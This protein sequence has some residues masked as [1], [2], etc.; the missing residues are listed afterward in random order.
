MDNEHRQGVL[1]LST[2]NEGVAEAKPRKS[3]TKD[4]FIVLT[5]TVATFIT[6][7]GVCL[8]IMEGVLAALAQQVWQ[9]AGFVLLATVITGTVLVNRGLTRYLKTRSRFSAA[10]KLRKDTPDAENV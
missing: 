6:F 1:H 5:V 2:S 9:G 7:T 10:T 3:T 4:D 8:E